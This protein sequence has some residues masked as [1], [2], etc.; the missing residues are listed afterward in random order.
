MGQIFIKQL[1]D[2]W[3][4]IFALMKDDCDGLTEQELEKAG[5]A[6]YEEYYIKKLQRT[7]FVTTFS[8]NI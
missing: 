5:K 8:H 1:Y 6:F 2:Y 7:R 3:N 4:N